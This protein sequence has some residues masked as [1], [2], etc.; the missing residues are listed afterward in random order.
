MNATAERLTLEAME[1]L[2]DGEWVLIDDLDID[3]QD[4]VTGGRVVCHSVNRDEVDLAARALG[5]R[6]AAVFY[7][8]APRVEGEV[9]LGPFVTG[10][11]AV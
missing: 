11:H 10:G 7:M 6:G 5:G 2:Y 4:L 8:G 3:A 1:H 9:I